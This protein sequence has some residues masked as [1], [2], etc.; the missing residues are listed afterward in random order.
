MLDF[1]KE[2]QSVWQRLQKTKKPIL[3]YGM[4][5]GAAKIIK[6]LERHQI[7]MAGIFA[8]DEF[9]RGNC[10][11]G[12]KIQKLSTLVEQFGEPFIVTT[13]G[14]HDLAL[15][16][17]LTM[18]AT[19]YELVAPDVPV[20]GENIFDLAFMEC[21]ATQIE[22]AF[23]LLADAQ[24]QTVFANVINY[25]LSGKIEYLQACTTTEDEAYQ[26]ILHLTQTEHYADLG[27]Y[28]GDTILTFLAHT[29][30]QYSSIT[31]LE[32]DA[33]NY[34]KLLKMVEARG[35]AHT[36]CYN[37]AV[38]STQAQLPFAS[39]GGRNSALASGQGKCIAANSLD[40]LLEGKPVTFVNMDVEGAEKQA[41]A[42]MVQTI[43]THRPKLLVAAYH[44]SED[45]FA[46]LLQI[47]AIRPQYRFYLRHYRY[48]PAW[49]TNLYCI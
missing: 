48:I 41:L 2:T 23:H 47:H 10:F 11:M 13:F 15:T 42:G 22:Q 14:I 43:C 17:R 7:S 40:N 3:L 35:L 29:N 9:V 28:R 27:A 45:I 37:M 18:L 25:K 31:A 5:D 24:S 33:K 46:L 20:A 21:H 8:S 30:G 49:D 38:H 39:R 32:P 34:A 4:G 19:Q 12:H 1:I 44:R 36:C 6:E 16:Q 26:A